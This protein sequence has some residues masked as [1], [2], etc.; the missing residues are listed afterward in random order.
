[1]NEGALAS[2][3]A[4]LSD[5]SVVCLFEQRAEYRTGSSIEQRGSNDNSL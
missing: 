2:C 5:L 3:G 4:V 1:M